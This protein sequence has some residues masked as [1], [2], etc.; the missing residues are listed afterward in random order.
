[1]AIENWRTVPSLNGSADTG[2][3]LFPE[4]MAPSRVND[5]A[6]TL[7]AEI[8]KWYQVF[9]QPVAL[10]SALRQGDYTT[11]YGVT[12][13][14]LSSAA[15]PFSGE[16]DFTALVQ[17]PAASSGHTNEL[18]PTIRITQAGATPLRAANDGILIRDEI[19]ASL[20]AL[21]TF[22]YSASGQHRCRVH[23][24]NAATVKRVYELNQD[25][26]AF[27]DVDHDAVASLLNSAAAL[28]DPI[29]FANPLTAEAVAAWWKEVYESNA[30]TNAYADD[31]KAAVDWLLSSPP[32]DGETLAQ[33]LKRVAGTEVYSAAE[34]QKLA[35]IEGGAEVN[36]TDDELRTILDPRYVQP[37]TDVELSAITAASLTTSGDV[38]ATGNVSGAAGNFTGDVT[39]FHISGSSD[40]RMKDNIVP[41]DPVYA[42]QVVNSLKVRGF[43]W[44]GFPESVSSGL[45]AQEVQRVLPEAVR[46]AKYEQM[47][48]ID[49]LPVIAYLAGAV[50][51][52]TM[53]VK[54]LETDSGTSE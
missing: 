6:R 47:L 48:S 28:N 10:T 22:K 24:V 14:T 54:E 46:G 33:Y 12:A 53:R 27:T 41:I 38:T 13:G 31:A 25:T 37:N 39:A 49:P 20:L 21:L 1:M 2:A 40:E 19:P 16:A 45:I 36:H 23:W 17:F 42:L 32:V 30:D 9:G 3:G 34:K 18:A 7:I 15:W 4:G 35:G 11:E 5:D 52:L 8:A 43:K 29:N 50:Q 51:E 44:R 26:N